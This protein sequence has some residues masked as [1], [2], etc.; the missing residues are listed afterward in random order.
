MAFYF[1]WTVMIHKALKVAVAKNLFSSLMLLVQLALM[2]VA[3]LCDNWK[4][5][6]SIKV[7][8]YS[9]VFLTAMLLISLKQVSWKKWIFYTLSS[10]QYG[11][12]TKIP[13]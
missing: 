8:L 9:E 1:F 7:Y 12:N 2:N 5:L 4:T 6:F 3:I 11:A 10:Q 13:K